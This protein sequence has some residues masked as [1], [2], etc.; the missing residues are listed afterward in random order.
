MMRFVLMLTAVLMTGCASVPRDAGLAEVRERTGTT[1]EWRRDL[2]QTDD[3]RVSALLS[4]ELDA[5]SA[6]AVAMARNPRL[7]VILA[8]LGIAQ[9]ELMEASTISNPVLEYETRFPGEPHRPYEITLA[10]SLI[11]LIQLPRRREIG[12]ATF[13]AA[14]LRVSSEVLR[15]AATVRESYYAAVA[16]SASADLSR[17]VTEAARTSAELAVRQHAAGNITDLDLENEQALYEQARI[18]L[19]RSEEQL[20]VAREAFIRVL[21]L[22]DAD[23]VVTIRNEFPALPHHD[24]S[25]EELDALLQARRLDIAIAQ[26]EVEI[27]QR[28]VPLARVAALGDVVVDVH[29]ER[30]PEGTKTTG[31]GIEFPIPI[32]N[33]GRAARTRAEAEF[34]RARYRLADVTGR[35]GS[36]ARTAREKLMAA[37]SR[38]E[39]YRDVVLPRRARIVELTKLEHNAMLA[40]AYQLLQARQDE[41]NA[42]RE[43]IDAQRDY[44]SARVNLDRVI[45]GIGP[46]D[47]ERA[48]GGDDRRSG[49]VSR[50]GD[51]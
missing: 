41:A 17:T 15:F 31:P 38:A 27:A 1:I 33:T 44:W 36:E 8:D 9:S 51:H 13:E 19:G 49:E 45:N 42:R 47:F 46:V 26:Q 32:F 34:L 43:Y 20:V 25:A 11:D 24:V 5:E 14:K 7:Q 6:V 21:G 12:Q 3:P 40:G 4:R 37:R 23:P 18:T 10:Q 39:Y 28:R 16:A 48:E 29:R 22:L 50:R 35:A 30:E 2:S